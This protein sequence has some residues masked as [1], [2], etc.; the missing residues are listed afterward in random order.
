MNYRLK[1][2]RRKIYYYGAYVFS[3]LVL[4]VPY[5]FSIGFLSSFFGQLAYY[6]AIDGARNAKA[7]LRKCFP[8]KS[9]KDIKKTV[10]KIF[11]L[12][13]KNFF[14][15]ANFPRMDPEFIKSIAFVENFDT[16]QESIKKGK[17]VLFA[18]AQTGNWK[19]TATIMARMGI[20]VNVVAKK[21]YIDGLN[22][23]LVE[24]RESKNI[25]VI[26]R[27]SRDSGIKLLRA[28][29]K[30]RDYSNAYRSRCRC[31]WCFC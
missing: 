10:K 3:K 11:C 12:E 7:N 4:M 5:K 15:I 21:I 18:S 20:Q 14:E 1:K 30:R 6:T 23:M 19:I 16:I 29:K 31:S 9:D 17:R 2:I 28:L 8:E 27:E 13:A 22:D 25:K 26:L 24:Y